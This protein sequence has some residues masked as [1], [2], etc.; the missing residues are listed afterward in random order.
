MYNRIEFML[1]KDLFQE[2]N[3]TNVTL[4]HMKFGVHCC[5]RGLY[6]CNIFLFDLRIVIVIE[7]IKGNY[8]IFST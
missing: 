2:C 3:I 8:R 5:G 6:F 7:A 1:E 4:G